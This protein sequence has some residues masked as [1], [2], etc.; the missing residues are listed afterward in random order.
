MIIKSDDY[1]TLHA[2]T[3]CNHIFIFQN[4]ILLKIQ[5]YRQRILYNNKHNFTNRV[6]TVQ[7]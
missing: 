7:Q 6:Y 5:F 1:Q 2:Y 4:T 3:Y